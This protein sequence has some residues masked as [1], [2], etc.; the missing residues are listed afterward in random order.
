MFRGAS[1]CNSKLMS[2]PVRYVELYTEKVSQ[3]LVIALSYF[4][5][6]GV[7]QRVDKIGRRAIVIAATFSAELF[8]RNCT[9]THPQLLF[10]VIRFPSMCVRRAND[11]N[12]TSS[13]LTW[14]RVRTALSAHGTLH[15]TWAARVAI[16]CPLIAVNF[17]S[18]LCPPPASRSKLRHVTECVS[19]VDDRTSFLCL[20]VYVKSLLN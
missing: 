1:A 16:N 19:F 9:C 18:R 14:R 13:L 2:A 12:E 15:S 20:F 4:G 5:T 10:R 7:S 3:L 8:V 11:T 6:S 17:A